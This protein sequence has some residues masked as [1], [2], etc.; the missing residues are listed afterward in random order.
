MRTTSTL[1]RVGSTA[2][3]LCAIHC[4]ALG[5]IAMMLPLTSTGFLSSPWLEGLFFGV[6]MIVGPWAWYSGFKV[7]RCWYPGALIV[8]GLT[9]LVLSHFVGHDHSTTGSHT[10]Q[11]AGV[12]LSAVGGMCVVGFH[13]LNSRYVRRHGCGHR[14]CDHD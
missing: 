10:H 12:W 6:A 13:V 5:L 8:S 1:D 9:L 3:F 11:G 2:G 7:H 4:F 14:G